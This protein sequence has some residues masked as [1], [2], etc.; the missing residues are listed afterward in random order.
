MRSSTLCLIGNPPYLSSAVSFGSSKAIYFHM[1]F[2]TPTYS[3]LGANFSGQLT[4]LGD[5]QGIINTSVQP[6]TA[7]WTAAMAC[8]WINLSESSEG[9]CAMSEANKSGH[10]LECHRHRPRR[11]CRQT[12]KSI[13]VSAIKIHRRKAVKF[14]KP[15]SSGMCWVRCS[16]W[17]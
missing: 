2:D 15:S 12:G 9:G 7:V 17:G 6:A 16:S 5:F 11:V 4:H 8:D 13:H 3:D 1:R 14:M 10:A